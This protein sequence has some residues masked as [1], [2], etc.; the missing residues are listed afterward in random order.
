MLLRFLFSNIGFTISVFSAF[1]FFITGWLYIDSSSIER[2]KRNLVVRSIGFFLLALSSAASATTISSTTFLLGTQ[3]LEITALIIIIL[4]LLS[5]PMLSPPSKKKVLIFFPVF[6]IFTSFFSL[7]PLAAALYFFI[8]IIF[9]RKVVQNYEKQLRPVFWAFIFL[10][11]AKALSMGF[12]WKDTTDVFLSN[13]L[14]DFGTLWTITHFIE[15]IGLVILAKWTLGYIRFRLA[16]QLFVST[17]SASL[18]IFLVT[19][20]FFTFL[21]LGNVEQDALSHL[22]TDVRVLQYAIERL[23]KEALSDVQ[24]ISQ[25]SVFLRAF[26][27]NDKKELL[28]VTSNYLVSQNTNFLAVT[29]K[30]GDVMMRAED[31]EKIGDNIGFDPVVRSALSGHKLSTVIVSPGVFLPLVQIKAATPVVIGGKVAGS[32]TTGFLVDEAFVDGVKNITGLDVTVFAERKRAA[33]TFLLPDGKSRAVGTI[34][35]NDAVISK[36]LEKGEIFL[37]PSQVLNQSYYTA[38]APLKTNGDKTIGMLFVGKQQTELIK[39]ANHS[40]E[41]TFLGSII[42]MIVSIFPAFY[43]AR[44]MQDQ[45][46]A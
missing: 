6:G 3:W 24:S 25:D 29:G 42:L 40:L 22:K 32:V 36:V 4:D 33:T 12:L 14:S 1:V 34:E 43:I 11:A 39:A 13:F 17:V 2:D 5:E 10:A 41:L 16:S 18:L 15:L 45:V 35:S 37:G 28:K 20:I 23:Q 30:D 21:L 9:I 31:K 26:E 7:I 38:Y 8:A 44:Y 46:S 27:S 19:T